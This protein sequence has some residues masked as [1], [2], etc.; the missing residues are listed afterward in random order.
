MCCNR[1]VFCWAVL[2]PSGSARHIRILFERKNQKLED[3]PD[4]SCIALLAYFAYQVTLKTLPCLA[5]LVCAASKYQT[6]LTVPKPICL[7]YTNPGL[8]L[9]RNTLIRAA[10]SWLISTLI[11]PLLLRLLHLWQC[12]D[13]A[14]IY[15]EVLWQVDVQTARVAVF[16]FLCPGFY[17]GCGF[18]PALHS[19]SGE[20]E[21]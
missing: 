20:G 5:G 3:T 16:S 15:R 4:K 8:P 19:W 12:V 18:A 2:F 17:L 10:L 11:W 9:K 14:V 6:W 7:L 13:W 21:R 1:V